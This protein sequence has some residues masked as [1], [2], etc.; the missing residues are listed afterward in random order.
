MDRVNQRTAEAGPGLG[1]RVDG[2]DHPGVRGGVE[3][4]EPLQ[5]LVGDVDLPLTEVHD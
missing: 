4:I 2:L 1:E 3:A 5:D